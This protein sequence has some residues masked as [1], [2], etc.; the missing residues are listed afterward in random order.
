MY[1]IT[2]IYIRICNTH[3][4]ECDINPL[5]V[6]IVQV[7]IHIDGFRDC[8]RCVSAS[9]Q[10]AGIRFPRVEIA[11]FQTRVRA[12]SRYLYLYYKIYISKYV[13]ITYIYLYIMI[14]TRGWPPPH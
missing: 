12:I 11:R 1:R 6:Q 10:F 3:V 2:A 14:M 13:N 7:T 9:N 8:S 4:Y 5:I